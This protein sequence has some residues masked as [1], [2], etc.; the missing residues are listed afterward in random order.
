MPFENV[1]QDD[2]E[3]YAIVGVVVIAAMFVCCCLYKK[4]C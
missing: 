1:N 4:C 3:E 2:V